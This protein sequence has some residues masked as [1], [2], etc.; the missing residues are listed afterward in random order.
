MSRKQALQV[1]ITPNLPQRVSFTHSFHQK[2]VSEHYLPCIMQSTG[3]GK[4]SRMGNLF[5]KM[6]SNGGGHAVFTAHFTHQE[7]EVP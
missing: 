4:E 6:S 5:I 7:T 3:G 2:L 1:F